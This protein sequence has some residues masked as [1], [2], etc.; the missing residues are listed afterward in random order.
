MK[1]AVILIGQPRTF[2]VTAKT[3]YNSL[4]KDNKDVVLFLACETHEYYEISEIIKNEFPNITVGGVITMASYRDTEFD[5]ICNMI[6]NSS[7]AGLSEDVFERSRNAD[8]MQ[9][10]CIGQLIIS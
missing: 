2:K 6:C 9:M 3:L 10:E 4:F 7:R 5:N 1:T 8:E